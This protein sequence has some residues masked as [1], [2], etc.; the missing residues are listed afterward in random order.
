MIDVLTAYQMRLGTVIDPVVPDLVRAFKARPEVFVP[1]PKPHTTRARSR[2]RAVLFN[3]DAI[4][5]M[6]QKLKD[7]FLM[8]QYLDLTD[9]S[10]WLYK[11]WFA[12]L[13][14]IV[15]T[16]PTFHRLIHLF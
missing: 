10:S 16:S 3:I 11:K 2:A 12:P 14:S 8:L 5:F 7:V 1:S 13:Y 6:S 4:H 9:F 15:S